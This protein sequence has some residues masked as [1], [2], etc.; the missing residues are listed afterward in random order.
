MRWMPAESSTVGIWATAVAAAMTPAQTPIFRPSRLIRRNKKAG[1]EALPWFHR[2]ASYFFSSFFSSFLT[3]FLAAFLPPF[4]LSPFFISSFLSVGLAPVWDI[5]RAAPLETANT[6]ATRT[7][8]SFL[9]F[10]SRGVKD[11]VATS[12]LLRDQSL[13]LT[14]FALRG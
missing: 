7:E 2:S 10:S 14:P 13:P 1:L 11:R 3:S 9:I 12:P 4:F 5:A 6:A 8:I